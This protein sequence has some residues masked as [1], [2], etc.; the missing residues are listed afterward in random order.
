MGLTLVSHHY[1]ENAAGLDTASESSDF[2]FSTLH[3]VE[4]TVIPFAQIQFFNL[5]CSVC[6]SGSGCRNEC[7]CF[8]MAVGYSDNAGVCSKFGVIS[9]APTIIN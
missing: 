8:N 7:S 5:L 9:R 6:H 2:V 1:E 4:A 3:G